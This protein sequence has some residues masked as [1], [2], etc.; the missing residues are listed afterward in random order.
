MKGKIE[1]F[2]D[3]IDPSDIR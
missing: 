1:I 2:K 3:D